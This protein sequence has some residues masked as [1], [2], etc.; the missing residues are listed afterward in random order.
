MAARM[1]RAGKPS[2]I[3]LLAMVTL[4][5]SKGLA[6]EVKIVAGKIEQLVEKV[7]VVVAE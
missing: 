7:Q 4:C 2:D 5:S 3:E 6:H 1:K